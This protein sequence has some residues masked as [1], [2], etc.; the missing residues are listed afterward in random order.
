M[1]KKNKTDAK[2]RIDHDLNRPGEIIIERPEEMEGE[3]QRVQTTKVKLG[4]KLPKL[5]DKREVKQ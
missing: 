1:E 5:E 3:E 2:K 4:T